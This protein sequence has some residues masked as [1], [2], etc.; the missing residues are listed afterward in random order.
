MDDDRFKLVPGRIDHLKDCH[1]C[2]QDFRY[3]NEYIVNQQKE[4][5]AKPDIIT[6][7]VAEEPA[8]KPV[9]QPGYHNTKGGNLQC[10]LP[11][12][13]DPYQKK[14]KVHIHSSFVGFASICTI[15]VCFYLLKR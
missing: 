11:V 2:L 8:G 10:K 13:N 1:I 5:L 14:Y 9:D 3:Q 12:K 7:P 4:P 15:L 6:W